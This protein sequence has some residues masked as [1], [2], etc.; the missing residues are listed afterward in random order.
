[1]IKKI[2]TILTMTICL[3]LFCGCGK[4][5]VNA[6]V[7]NNHHFVVIDSQTIGGNWLYIV[8]DNSNKVVYTFGKG[9]LSPLYN[10]SGTPMTLDEYNQIK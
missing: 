4:D 7:E 5:E 10:A 2:L 6:N 9:E 8:Y 3:L 1:M